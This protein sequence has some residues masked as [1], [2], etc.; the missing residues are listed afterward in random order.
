MKGT[1]VIV[2]LAMRAFGMGSAWPQAAD[3]AQWRDGCKWRAGADKP[4]RLVADSRGATSTKCSGERHSF[5]S[6]MTRRPIL[7]CAPDLSAPRASDQSQPLARQYGPRHVRRPW[8][9]NVRQEGTVSQTALRIDAGA[10]GCR[11]GLKRPPTRP[12]LPISRRTERSLTNSSTAT[13]RRG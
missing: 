8:W 4:T 6:D 11:D 7:P 5:K 12:N 2:V 9:R 1:V 3:L 10:T 13:T